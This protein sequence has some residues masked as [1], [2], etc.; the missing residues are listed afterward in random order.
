[1]LKED[2]IINIYEFLHD[3]FETII[4]NR[5]NKVFKS[6]GNPADI[7]AEPVD[8]LWLTGQKY[9]HPYRYKHNNGVFKPPY[10]DKDVLGRGDA[11]WRETYT[12]QLG[13][14]TEAQMKSGNKVRNLIYKGGLESL[15]SLD[16]RITQVSGEVNKFNRV[17]N[18]H[19]GNISSNAEYEGQSQYL[20]TLDNDL[21]NQSIAQFS[22]VEDDLAPIIRD[23][24]GLNGVKD[25][26]DKRLDK[27]L[28]DLYNNDLIDLNNFTRGDN[29]ELTNASKNSI[30]APVPSDEDVSWV[31]KIAPD[32]MF[33][34]F[35]IEDTTD[36]M[37]GNLAQVRS[38]Y[39][40]LFFD[41]TADPPD[42]VDGATMYLS[43][44][45][46]NELNASLETLRE[47]GIERYVMA[48]WEN[49]ENNSI[50][51][52]EVDEIG[53]I[54]LELNNPGIEYIFMNFVPDDLLRDYITG[55]K[56]YLAGQSGNRIAA[57]AMET[58]FGYYRMYIEKRRE[59]IRR[60]LEKINEVVDK[61]AIPN[62]KLL[63]YQNEFSR[64]ETNKSQIISFD[65]T[66]ND[67]TLHDDK[68]QWWPFAPKNVVDAT[69]TLDRGGGRTM[70]LEGIVAQ[71]WAVRFSKW[72]RLIDGAGDITNYVPQQDGVPL[73]IS[74][75]NTY[76]WP[77]KYGQ[78]AGTVYDS[79]KVRLANFDKTGEPTKILDI[80]ALAS[81]RTYQYKGNTYQVRGDRG[82]PPYQDGAGQPNALLWNNPLFAYN[83]MPYSH[84]NNEFTWSP[85]DL[86]VIYLIRAGFVNTDIIKKMVLD[87]F[88]WESVGFAD[89]DDVEVKIIGRWPHIRFHY[90]DF[91][92]EEWYESNPGVY[93]NYTGPLYLVDD[94]L[95]FV[96]QYR[97][98]HNKHGF[99]EDGFF[100]YSGENEPRHADDWYKFTLASGDKANGLFAPVPQGLIQA[101]PAAAG[102]G[103]G[104]GFRLDEN[105]HL[106]NLAEKDILEVQKISVGLGPNGPR[107]ENFTSAGRPPYNDQYPYGIPK[108][109]DG[110]WLSV[111]GNDPQGPVFDEVGWPARKGYRRGS[112]GGEARPYL[113]IYRDKDD[114]GF[115]V[116]TILT[117]LPDEFERGF[118]N[119]IKWANEDFEGGAPLNKGLE[120]Y[121]L[122]DFMNL[123][124]QG[125]R[126]AVNGDK[127][128]LNNPS[129]DILYGDLFVEEAPP[130]G[131]PPLAEITIADMSKQTI[132]NVAEIPIKRE[133]VDN[134]L[135]R[136]NVNMSLLQF[137]QQILSPSSIGLNGNVHIGV[138][139]N[140]AN[141]MELIPASISYKGISND[142][143]ENAFEANINNDDSLNKYLVFDYKKRNSLIE[144]VDMSSK[145]DPAAFLTYQNSSNL[146]RGRDYNVL[147]LLSYEGVAEDFKQYLDNTPKLDNSG[148]TYSGIINIGID[149]KV[150]VNKVKFEQI[151]SAI[152]DGA[153]AQN[154]E[155]WARIIAIMQG[156]DNFTTELL[157]FY[158][159]GATLIIH[160]TTNIRP[161]NLIN[162]TGVLPN[163][164]GLYI[165]TNIT[166]KVTPTTFQT[167]IE[168]KLLKRKR[169]VP[170]D[171]STE[172]VEKDVFI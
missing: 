5:L 117:S 164:E 153:I 151:P 136:N 159:R 82:D 98:T 79:G 60:Y 133:V 25:F 64:L 123:F 63:Q 61:M 104:R 47:R 19:E 55:H 66:F 50:N 147:K 54:R 95:D 8:L 148:E 68:T 87:A 15:E 142:M 21:N 160:G 38:G 90:E 17:M 93:G 101:Y 57:N 128:F 165:V 146:L 158:M 28:V 138:R 20:V 168:G 14:W 134:L 58:G 107:Y 77:Q 22:S 102:A 131:T 99:D 156:G 112:L 56:M 1:M 7:N 12:N 127:P 92:L 114:T 4:R 91:R 53:E 80:D 33:Q 84:P 94:D 78:K 51:L 137:M 161:F 149:N 143:F 110:N 40:L 75:L 115:N 125:R 163:L 35:M 39:E 49:T 62:S 120:R 126:V 73:F 45:P 59:L 152:M 119:S 166:E 31:S 169:L 26:W 140:S 100:L 97:S 76:G 24:K 157:A 135:S 144:S 48:R 72:S 3:H 46:H 81:R 74:G 113:G 130:A 154:P 29:W 69:V 52:S 44:L 96:M 41:L 108:D 43:P 37:Y 23:Y 145:M 11:I 27:I 116:N 106:I 132:Q 141:I 6:N 65:N 42:P 86:D 13:E 2:G 70:T 67:P 170:D 171:P 32:Y 83:Y 9:K 71:Y 30:T 18:G 109:E 36:R 122:T 88:D 121:I 172:E 89:D 85:D 10:N 105:N 124:N 111:G 150:S 139:T 34:R 118:F 16:E 103:G 162:I 167:I 129:A 155:R